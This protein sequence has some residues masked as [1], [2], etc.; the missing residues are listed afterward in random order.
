MDG[1]ELN[2]F[3]AGV[4]LALL[5]GM[6]ASMVSKSIVH[7]K[8]L[9]KNVLEISGA[10][11]ASVEAGA[12]AVAAPQEA[13]PIQP[14]LATASVENGEKLAKKYC[15]QCHSFESGGAHKIGPNLWNAVGNKL[16]QKEGFTYSSAIK[17]MDAE[18]SYENL[19]KFLFKPRSF[20]SGTKMSF[21][22]LAKVQDRA[23][24]ISYLRTLRSTPLP[25]P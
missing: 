17:A 18:W 23:D 7:P 10:E 9:E 2:K 5:V 4:I 19:N 11:D 6:V 12:G 8:M 20:V 14:L 15:T 1:F 25:L 21:A 3:A 24:V 22:G 16:A 13:E